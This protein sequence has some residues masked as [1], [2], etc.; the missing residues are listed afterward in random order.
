MTRLPKYLP[1]AQPLF[2]TPWETAPHSP[3]QT[4]TFGLNSQELTVLGEFPL[5]CSGPAPWDPGC[6]TVYEVTLAWA[7]EVKSLGALVQRDTFPNSELIPSALRASQI[8]K[9]LSKYS[10]V[11]CSLSVFVLLK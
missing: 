2:L 6:P 4:V 1:C 5:L 7:R 3:L 9:A 11:L 8:V 10:W